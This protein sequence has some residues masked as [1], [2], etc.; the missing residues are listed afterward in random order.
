MLLV[1]Q[2][3][4]LG[5]A[6]LA[7]GCVVYFMNQKQPMPFVMGMPR[8]MQRYP[9]A[10]Q[11]W[12]QQPKR[13]G[14]SW[15]IIDPKDEQMQ[16]GRVGNSLNQGAPKVENGMLNIPIPVSDEIA[17]LVNLNYKKPTGARRTKIERDEPNAFLPGF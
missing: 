6:V 2:S 5:V 16:T 11:Y 3:M 13:E 15:N 12:P 17:N 8:Q 1:P 7:I 9:Q 14:F 4:W 10:A